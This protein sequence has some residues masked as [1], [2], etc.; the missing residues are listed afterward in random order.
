[1]AFAL[2]DD[3]GSS[4]CA[5]DQLEALRFPHVFFHLPGTIFE[6]IQ[7]GCRLVVGP[8]VPSSGSF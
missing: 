4:A 5:L 7:V 8:C 3:D 2:P 6:M 1:V